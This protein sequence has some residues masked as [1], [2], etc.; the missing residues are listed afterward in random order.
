MCGEPGSDVGLRHC[1]SWHPNS[2]VLA[3]DCACEGVQARSCPALAPIRRLASGARSGTAN[4][5][6]WASRRDRRF[7]A[8]PSALCG[9]W[10]R[11]GPGARDALRSRPVGGEGGELA[12]LAWATARRPLAASE[13][14]TGCV[15]ARGAA[16]LHAGGAAARWL[17]RR[18]RQERAAR[19]TFVPPPRCMLSSPKLNARRLPPVVPGAWY[20][21]RTPG[22]SPS[23]GSRRAPPL[24]R[25]ILPPAPQ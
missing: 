2:E 23:S 8:A 25:P 19:L 12:G 11:V 22:R 6:R 21:R 3:H 24:G 4:D 18:C 16:A 7:A 1:S 9:G 13:L 14:V 15:S 5:C 20:A 10:G 17:A